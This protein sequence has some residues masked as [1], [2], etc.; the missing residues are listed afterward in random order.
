L[1][2]R[3][4]GDDD[5]DMDRP[6]LSLARRSGGRFSSAIGILSPVQNNSFGNIYVEV[7]IVISS[8]FSWLS[9]SI[10]KI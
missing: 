9:T 7:N 6:L 3:P 1:V 5:D 10:G 4:L 2:S 8:K